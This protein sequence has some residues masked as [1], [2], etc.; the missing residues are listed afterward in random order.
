MTAVLYGI[1]AA[2][3]LGVCLFLLMHNLTG[4]IFG[5]GALFFTLACLRSSK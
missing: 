3:F 2:F 4:A 5:G 1:G